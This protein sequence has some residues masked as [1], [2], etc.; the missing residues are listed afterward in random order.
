MDY[1]V[2][3]F[4]PFQHTSKNQ[5]QF[6]SNFES[7]NLLYAYEVNIHEYDL[8]LQN[9]TNTRGYNQWFYFSYQFNE[10]AETTFNIVSMIKKKT[11]FEKGVKPSFF[12]QDESCRWRQ[13]TSSVKYFKNGVHRENGESYYTLSFKYAPGTKEKVYFS[14]NLPYTYTK[15]ISLVKEVESFDSESM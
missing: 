7:G 10:L 5:S 14:L 1:S 12:V 3:N 15:M 2:L 6:D 11:L 9:D 8:V 4:V 13:V